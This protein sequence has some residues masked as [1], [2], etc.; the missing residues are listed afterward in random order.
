MSTHIIMAPMI[1]NLN[2]DS[3]IKMK[4]SVFK[5]KDLGLSSGGLT[6]HD[7]SLMEIDTRDASKMTLEQK[8]LLESQTTRNARNRTIDLPR[9]SVD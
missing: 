7:L 5:P 2:R 4:H 8:K 6:P 9:R 1:Q 3:A